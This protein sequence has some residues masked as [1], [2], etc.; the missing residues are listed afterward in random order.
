MLVFVQVAVEICFIQTVVSTA[1]LLQI[2]RLT[3]TGNTEI[4]LNRVYQH[5]QHQHQLIIKNQ[6]PDRAMLTE[7]FYLLLASVRL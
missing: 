5:P 3:I 4:C 7:A 6:D 2:V 1:L